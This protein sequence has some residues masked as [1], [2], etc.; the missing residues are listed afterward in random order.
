MR[1]ASGLVCIM[2]FYGRAPEKEGTGRQ[3]RYEGEGRND[4][5]SGTCN[6]GGRRYFGIS[7]KLLPEFFGTRF[8]EFFGT[9]LNLVQNSSAA[10][11]SELADRWTNEYD[12]LITFYS[13]I[14]QR[15]TELRTKYLF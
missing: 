1:Y 4:R 13:Y 14:Y 9:T 6:Q 15:V 12:G 3:T 10:E 5:I 7:L 2:P 8:P 11:Q